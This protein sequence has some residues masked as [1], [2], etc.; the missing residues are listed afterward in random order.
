MYWFNTVWFGSEGHKMVGGPRV[1]TPRSPPRPHREF[2]T[3]L[4]DQVPARCQLH[5]RH[6]GHHP[7]SLQVPP[8][9][10]LSRSEVACATWGFALKVLMFVGL[11]GWQGIQQVCWPLAAGPSHC[12]GRHCLVL[13]V[14]CRWVRARG[15]QTGPVSARAV[16]LHSLVG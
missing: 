8:L 9:D 5:L 10:A 2:G 11:G 12:G 6:R 3:G 4:E 7:G 15:G 14:I 1:N 13:S 16:L